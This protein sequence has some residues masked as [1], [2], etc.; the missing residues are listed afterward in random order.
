VSAIDDRQTGLRLTLLAS[1]IVLFVLALL[2]RLWFLQILAGARF[3]ELSQS[4]AVRIVTTEAPR[5]RILASDGTPLVANRAAPTVV[6]DRQVLLNGLGDP[7]EGAER[8]LSDLAQVLGLEVD[9]LL[10][11]LGTRKYSPF[12]PVPVL[13]DVPQE[14]RFYIQEHQE[15]FPGVDVVDLPVRTYPQGQDAA[16]ILGYL[17]EISAIQLTEGTFQGYRPGEK[18]GQAGLEKTYELDLQGQEGSNRLSVSARG[19][20]LEVLSTIPPTH[21][22]DLVTNIDFELQ[23]ATETILEQGVLAS[24]NIVRRDGRNLESIAGSAVILR[25]SDGAVLAM[26]SWPTFD[27]SAFVDGLTDVE[28]DAIFDK[29]VADEVPAINRAIQGAYPPGSVFKIVSGAA[30]LE[31]GLIT[32]DSRVACPSSWDLGNI[33]FNNWNASS[34]GAMDLATALKRS[35]DTFFYE[36]AYQQYVREENQL[37]TGRD[38]IEQLERISNGFG[39]G[40]ELGIDLP[41]EQDGVIPSRAWKEDYWERTR[42]NNCQLASDAATQLAVDPNGSTQYAFD[43]YTELCQDGYRFRGG[44]AVNASIGQGDVLTTPLQV[45]ASY[46]AVANGG[47]LFRPRVADRIVA[48]DGSIARQIEPFAIGTLPVDEAGLREIRFG[49]EEV[50]MGSGGTGAG[51]FSGFPLDQIPVAGKT[52]TAELGSQI[53]YA[54]F[55]A[56][57]PADAPEYVVVVSVERGGG[58]SQTA[59]PIA[60]RILEAAFGLD[61]KPFAA[62]PEILD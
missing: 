5:G 20:V 46:A 39:F 37:D 27:P 62:G 8:V 40:I 25:P 56:Y 18:V 10:F 14:V 57:A 34:E 54:W 58:G 49:L 50:V 29:T 7:R 38:V 42:G 59:A 11:R 55:A 32:T 61:V 36:L 21:G 24:R 16:H 60:R 17:G 1:V 23:R 2:S 19:T 26:A 4:N 48:A 15:F 51:A 52:G 44:D 47:T 31:S 53:P 43:L 3:D 22:S 35:C 45:A 41:S 28:F 13:E 6:V 33:T 30:A 12:S 9:E